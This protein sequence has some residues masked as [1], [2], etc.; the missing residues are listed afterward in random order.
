MTVLK[1]PYPERQRD[2][3]FDALATHIIRNG[4]KVPNPSITP[5]K[6]MGR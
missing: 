6:C 3:P 1:K 4:M 5:D 2:W